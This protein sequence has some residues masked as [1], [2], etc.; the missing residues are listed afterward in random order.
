MPPARTSW[1]T[2]YP[3]DNTS[4][5]SQ[6]RRSLPRPAREVQEGRHRNRRHFAGQRRF[7]RRSSIA[8]YGFTFPLLADEEKAVCQRFGV[9]KEK[10]MYGKKYMGVERSTFLIDSKGVLRREWRRKSK[11]QATRKK[12]WLPRRSS[13]AAARHTPSPPHQTSGALLGQVPEA[14]RTAQDLRSRYQRHDARPLGHLPVRGAR[15][16]HPDDRARESSTRARRDS[17]KPRATCARS[18]AFSTS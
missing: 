9:W 11:C 5:C 13:D 4:G 10:S 1:C 17:R 2:L 6:G 14:D 8:R 15:H 16:L 7:A 18:A 3:K 12:C